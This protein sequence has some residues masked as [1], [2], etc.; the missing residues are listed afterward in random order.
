MV[1]VVVG[2]RVFHLIII[3][4]VGC[5]SCIQHPVEILTITPMCLCA[6]SYGCGIGC[7]LLSEPHTR[8]K[9]QRLGAIAHSSISSSRTVP[10]S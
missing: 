3:N 8:V 4:F 1:V 6:S 5:V 2:C 9:V 10:S 7:W